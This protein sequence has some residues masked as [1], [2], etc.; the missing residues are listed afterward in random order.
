[1]KFGWISPDCMIRRAIENLAGSCSSEAIGKHLVLI[2]G[3]VD[4]AR[5]R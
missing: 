3:S 4:A 2:D 1:M 5:R